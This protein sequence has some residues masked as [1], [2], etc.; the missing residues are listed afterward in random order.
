MTADPLDC[1]HLVELVSDYLD[2]AL[3]P[4]VRATVRSHLRDCDGCVAYVDQLRA[5]VGALGALPR[6][7]LD[8]HFR[9]RILTAFRGWPG[10]IGPEPA[11]R[12]Q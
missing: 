11:E 3:P 1:Q 10:P 7:P 5:T 4:P 6:E 8:P 12:R 2:G 9:D